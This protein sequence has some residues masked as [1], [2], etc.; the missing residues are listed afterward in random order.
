M[1][2]IGWK[3]WA[4]VRMVKGRISGDVF[5]SLLMLSLRTD[6]L[7]SLSDIEATPLEL[8]SGINKV[9]FFGCYL[10]SLMVRVLISVKNYLNLASN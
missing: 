1:I 6:G 9:L 10:P 8:V 2:K 7:A 3:S 4:V 5:I